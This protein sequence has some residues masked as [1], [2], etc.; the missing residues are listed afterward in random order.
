MGNC[1]HGPGRLVLLL[2]AKE[3]K[4]CDHTYTAQTTSIPFPVQSSVKQ[5]N[6]K[7][8]VHFISTRE[9]KQIKV[10]TNIATS[11]HCIKYCPG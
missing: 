3:Q 4:S 11:Q 10:Y 9:E 7:H 6:K 2:V 1:T 8:K 5:E